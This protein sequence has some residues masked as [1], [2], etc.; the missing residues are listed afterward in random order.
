MQL[1]TILNRIEKHRSFV[2]GAIRLAEHEG[3]LALEIEIDPRANSRGI[4]SGC[5]QPGPGYDVLTT[6]RFVHVPLWGILVFF[7]YAMRRVDCPRCGVTVEV[8]P[9][10]T[11]K[12]QITTT[13]AWFLAKWAKRMSWID[14]AR[15]FHTSWD[16]VFRSVEMAVVWGRAHMDMTGITAIGVDE[17]AWR[18]GHKYLTLVYQINDGC[19]RLLWIGTDRKA[20]TLLA[21]FRWLTPARSRLLRF[22]CSD[23]WKPYLTVIAKKAGAAIHVLDRFHIMSHMNKAI[24]EVRAKEAREMKANGYEPVLTNSRWC[25]LKRPWNRTEKQNAKLADILRYNLRTVRSFLLREDFQFFWGYVSPYWAGQFLDG[26]CTRTLRS[27]IEPMKKV[28]RMLRKHRTLILNWFHAK[29]TI[30]SGSVEGLNNKAKL[31]TRRAYGFRSLRLIQI[32]LYHTLGNLPTPEHRF[33]RTDVMGLDDGRCLDGRGA[34]RSG[35]RRRRWPLGPRS[36]CYQKWRKMARLHA[37]DPGSWMVPVARK[38]G[39]H[40]TGGRILAGLARDDATSSFSWPRETCR[41]SNPSR[42]ARITA[43]A[44]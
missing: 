22:V 10:A 29:G 38:V 34:G 15:S 7:L 24:D 12:H 41:C 4:C 31:T 35:A 8:V 30:S 5:Q 42:G 26:W 14:V 23:M 32:A 3:R 1:K 33:S 11:G 13:Y 2:Y 17:I 44:C 25:L 40:W 16:T 36:P 9:W 21:F 18:K 37:A 28:A 19:K 20:K 39:R 6:R 27:R 43:T